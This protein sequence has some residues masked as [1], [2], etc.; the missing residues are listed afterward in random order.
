MPL[1]RL[2]LYIINNY[3]LLNKQNVC[4]VFMLVLTTKQLI[5]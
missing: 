1:H 4:V 3:I 5:D 2:Q